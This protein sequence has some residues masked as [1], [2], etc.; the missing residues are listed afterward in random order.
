MAEIK[1]EPILVTLENGEKLK[2]FD[3]A[4]TIGDILRELIKENG[5]EEVERVLN[6]LG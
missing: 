4:H 6:S 2:A 1:R 3:D 5:F